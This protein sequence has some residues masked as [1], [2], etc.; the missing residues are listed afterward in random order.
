MVTGPDT[1]NFSEI[2]GELRIAGA[3]TVVDDAAGLAT[4]IGRLLD[5]ATA[6]A[7]QTD[8]AARLL[9]T[10]ASVLTTTVDLLR[11][12]LAPVLSAPSGP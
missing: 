10:K 7:A 11:P 9:A 12:I 5:D 8:A 4:A 3:V 2:M 1:K 6:R